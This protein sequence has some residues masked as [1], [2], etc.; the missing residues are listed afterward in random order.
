MTIL[1]TMPMVVLAI[2][3]FIMAFVIGFAAGIHYYK[4][5]LNIP[6]SEK[7]CESKTRES[8][9]YHRRDL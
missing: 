9:C 7:I 4:N 8:R 3:L 2:I 5:I 1:I 6:Q